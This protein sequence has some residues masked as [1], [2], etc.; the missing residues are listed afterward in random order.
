MLR[1]LSRHRQFVALT[2]YGVAVAVAFVTG[3]A[4]YERHLPIRELLARATPP[5]AALLVVRLVL[6]RAY[7]LTL[8]RWRFVGTRDLVRLVLSVTAGTAIFAVVSAAPA[9][10]IDVP[11]PVLGLEWFFTIFLTAAAW[12]SYR[13]VFEHI[14]HRSGP[15]AEVRRVVIVGAGEAGNLLAREILRLPTGLELVGFVDDDPIKAGSLIHGVA[16]L[17][18][19]QEIGSIVRHHHVDQA[20]IAIPSATPGELRRIVGA[21]ETSALACKVLPGLSDALSGDISLEHVRNVTIEDLLGREPVSVE[22][23]ELADEVED[24]VVL[25]T[26]AGGSI[27]SEL[28]RQLA[29]NGPRRLILLDQ[30]ESDLFFSELEIRDRYPGLDLAAVVGDIREEPRITDVFRRYGVTHVYHAAAYKHVPL[31]EANA[32]EAVLNNVEGTRVLVDASGGAG[33]RTFVLVS[34]DKA[35]RPAN[36]MGATKRLCEHLLL[37]AVERY[38]KTRFTAVRF[39]NVLGS[40]GSVVQIFRKQI[41]QGR[42]TVTHPDITRYFMTV[43]EAVHLVLLAS[44]L[45]EARG[46]IAMLEMGEAVRILD[47]ARNMI[48]LSGLEEGR[49][50]DIEYTG[51]RPGEKLHEELVASFEV[52]S[53]TQNGKINLVSTDGP[54][55]RFQTRCSVLV[56]AARAGD[57]MRVR[58]L[59]LDLSAPTQP[60]HARAGSQLR[61]VPAASAPVG[62]IGVSMVGEDADPVAEESV[63]EA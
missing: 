7:R 35:V 34:T 55:E 1:V 26:G 59:L 9:L 51:L 46:R 36:V 29:A 62:A 50:V 19:V 13:V 22:L 63:L 60:L 54:A 44:L 17:G 57:D 52:V 56:E 33:V 32:A 48:R 41:K 39:G 24:A 53:R 23:P 5:L 21:C 30:A 28:A 40:N 38:P 2:V 27:G 6:H 31:M 25:V 15:D 47:L 18:P 12:I 14:R 16:V 10:R 20:I 42:L 4:F 37:D 3:W 11:G 8:G 58:D 61:D 43:S 45:E 49:D